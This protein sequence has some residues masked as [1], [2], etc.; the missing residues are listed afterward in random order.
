MNVAV[1]QSG[2]QG[3]AVQ[4]GGFR[5]FTDGLPD[6][7]VAADGYDFVAVNGDGFRVWMLRFAG[8]DFAI[9]ENAVRRVGGGRPCGGYK[10]ER[11]EYRETQRLVQHALHS[12]LRVKEIH[13]TM[14]QPY[15]NCGSLDI[16]LEMVKRIP[17]ALVELFLR[18]ICVCSGSG[19]KD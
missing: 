7:G 5:V 4:I 13:I 2:E 14:L 12:I 18:G 1:D 15:L 11:G 8:K 6:V 3:H 16:A 10:N 19:E 17:E 9:E